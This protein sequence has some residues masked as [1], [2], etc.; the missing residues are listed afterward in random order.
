MVT[1]NTPRDA[2]FYSA[3]FVWMTDV[4]FWALAHANTLDASPYAW[5]H[6]GPCYYAGRIVIHDVTLGQ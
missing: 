4:Q 5:G 3:H 2:P 1:A 6:C